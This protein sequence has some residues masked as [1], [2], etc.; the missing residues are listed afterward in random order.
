[1]PVERLV[2]EATPGH[3]YRLAYGNVRMGP[4]RYDLARTAGDP[5]SWVAQA[6][7]ATLGPAGRLDERGPLPP[8][9]ERHPVVVWALLTLLVAGLGLITWRTLRSD[10]GASMK[11]P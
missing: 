2:F 1:Q 10:D 7:A 6:G 4:P 5:A 3:Q 11:T 8:W 9:T